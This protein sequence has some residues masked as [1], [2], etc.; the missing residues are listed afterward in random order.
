MGIPR[1]NDIGRSAQGTND[2][3]NDLYDGTACAGG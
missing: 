3:P 1:R 2:T